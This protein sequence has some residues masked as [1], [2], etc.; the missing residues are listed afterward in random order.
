MRDKI[1]ATLEIDSLHLQS[2]NNLSSRGFSIPVS[3]PEKDNYICNSGKYTC[4][5]VLCTPGGIEG[6]QLTPG[7]PQA[8]Q[9]LL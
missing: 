6:H 7:W 9:C 2:S 4:M 1:T 3:F 8:K 5:S